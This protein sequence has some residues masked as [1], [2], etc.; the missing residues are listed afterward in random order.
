VSDDNR[1]NPEFRGG[2]PGFKGRNSPWKKLWI[3]GFRLLRSLLSIETYQLPENSTYP[4][5]IG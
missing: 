4:T 5:H 3:D 2:K 1:G